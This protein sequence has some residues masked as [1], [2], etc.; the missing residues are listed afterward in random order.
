[1]H[2]LIRVLHTDCAQQNALFASAPRVTSVLPLCYER[3][4]EVSYKERGSRRF[5]VIDPTVPSN[6]GGSS[7]LLTALWCCWQRNNFTLPRV[8]QQQLLISI[9][10]IYHRLV[11]VPLR[12][13]EARFSACTRHRLEEKPS[14]GMGIDVRRVSTSSWKSWPYPPPFL[15]TPS[16]L[17]REVSTSFRR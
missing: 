5:L 14:A 2:L 7:T 13:V 12:K 17:R 11:P 10:L 16:R 8:S 4:D 15:S 9:S 1:M 3:D 6:G